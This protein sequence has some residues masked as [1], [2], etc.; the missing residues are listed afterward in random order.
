MKCVS[1][2]QALNEVIWQVSMDFHLPTTAKWII[3][4]TSQAKFAI[5][6]IRFMAF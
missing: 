1:H 6:E 3:G 4:E 2:L 5:V